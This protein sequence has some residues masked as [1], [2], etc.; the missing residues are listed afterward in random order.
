[1][2]GADLQG[3]TVM[4]T[5]ILIAIFNGSFFRVDEP[6]HASELACEKAGKGLHDKLSETGMPLCRAVRSQGLRAALRCPRPQG[7]PQAST[8][9]V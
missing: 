9:T 3:G 5:W 7:E 1:M 6:R 4:E 2:I 8:A